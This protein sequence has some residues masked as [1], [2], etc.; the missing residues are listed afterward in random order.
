MVFINI[1][2]KKERRK[3]KNISVNNKINIYQNKYVLKYASTN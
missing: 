2:T 3:Q 1:C